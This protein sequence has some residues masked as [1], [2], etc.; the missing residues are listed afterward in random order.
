MRAAA[1]VQVRWRRG[2]VATRNSGSTSPLLC[3]SAHDVE[4][5]GRGPKLIGWSVIG[6]GPWERPGP[7]THRSRAASWPGTYVLHKF[8]SFHLCRVKTHWSRA[9][10]WP[11]TNDPIFENL[12]KTFVPAGFSNSTTLNLNPFEFE[13]GFK[14]LNLEKLS[15]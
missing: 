5:K 12:L 15:T 14:Y 3:L 10:P 6:P 7:L 11:G 4:G 9:F 13:N 8:A 2:A 1:G